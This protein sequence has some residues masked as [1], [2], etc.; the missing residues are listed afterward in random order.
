MRVGPLLA[1][2]LL[3]LAPACGDDDDEGGNATASC[4][5]KLVA[6]KAEAAL[7]SD[8]PAGVTGATFFDLQTDGA[9]KRYFAYATGTDVVSTRDTIRT[10]F[11]G[12]GFEIEGS[13]E[14]VPAEA[15]FEWT[16]GSNEGSVQVIPHCQGYVRIRY[17]T[18]PK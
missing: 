7:P 13:D 15:E 2:G 4:E 10:A 6:A 3:F 1:A 12:A 11:T 18:G 5:G 17:R 16:K 9:T 14:E 8:I